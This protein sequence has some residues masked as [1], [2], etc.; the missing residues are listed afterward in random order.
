MEFVLEGLTVPLS[1]ISNLVNESPNDPIFILN[2]VPL[3][4]G[5]F[6]P[7]DSLLVTCDLKMTRSCME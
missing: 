1:W 7:C 4:L 6:F 3:F 5:S 2:E